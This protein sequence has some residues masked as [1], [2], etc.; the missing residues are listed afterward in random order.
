MEIFRPIKGYESNYLVSNCGKVWSV[1]KEKYLRPNIDKYGYEYYV[2]CVDGKRKT[3]KAHRLVAETFIPNPDAK[4]TVDHINCDKRDNRVCNLR[5][6]T[7]KEQTNNPI[8][9]KKVLSRNTKEYMQKIGAIR[10]FGRKPVKVYKGKDLIGNYESLFSAANDLKVNYFKASECANGKRN[11]VGGY[12]F[13][14]V[15]KGDL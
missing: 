5:W 13:R 1:R 14:Y 6:A 2:F 3:L 12:E 8:T 15:E 7:N 9:Y 10:N 4:P 11:H